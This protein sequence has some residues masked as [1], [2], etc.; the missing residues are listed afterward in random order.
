MLDMLKRGE[1]IPFHFIQRKRKDGKVLDILASYGAVNKGK[2]LAVGM[3]KDFTGKDG[4][5]PE[6]EIKP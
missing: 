4:N 1:D 5:P 6:T 2:V 3:Y